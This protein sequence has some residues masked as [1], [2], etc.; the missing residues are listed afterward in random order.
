MNV[1]C[2]E[3]EKCIYRRPSGNCLILRDT[4]FNRPCPF[5][6]EKDTCRMKRYRAYS[7]NEYGY[8]SGMVDRDR[9]SW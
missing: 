9:V 6:K 8:E 4:K 5:R 2:N 1:K 3:K 7:G